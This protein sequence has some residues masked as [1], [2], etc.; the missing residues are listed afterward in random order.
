MTLNRRGDPPLTAPPARDPQRIEDTLCTGGADVH[1]ISP[2]AVRKGGG[3]PIQ[4]N[5]ICTST[6]YRTVPMP[7]LRKMFLF[8]RCSA[9]TVTHA[10][11]SGIP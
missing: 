3:T 2:A 6:M 8:H 7:M 1:D 4:M 11:S 9:M 5:T 10:M